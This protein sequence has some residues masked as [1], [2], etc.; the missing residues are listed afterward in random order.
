[1]YPSFP[2]FTRHVIVMGKCNLRAFQSRSGIRLCSLI[3]ITLD[4]QLRSYVLQLADIE[5]HESVNLGW[6][7]PDQSGVLINF[8]TSAVSIRLIQSRI[9]VICT[10]GN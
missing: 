10:S 8:L 5:S 2:C 3:A 6:H 4:S 1:M 9:L 7:R